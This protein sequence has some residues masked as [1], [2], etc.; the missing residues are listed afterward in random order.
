MRTVVS[1]SG[2]GESI[3]NGSLELGERVARVPLR[4]TNALRS[5]PGRQGQERTEGRAAEVGADFEALE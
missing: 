3:A 5:L 1:S 2:Y 4:P